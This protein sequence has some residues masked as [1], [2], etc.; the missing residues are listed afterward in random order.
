M[1]EPVPPMTNTAG[2]HEHPHDHP[3]A[4]PEIES[5]FTEIQA[6]HESAMSNLR[7]DVMAARDVEAAREAAVDAA[8]AAR[9]AEA[10]A[11]AAVMAAQAAEEITDEND[12]V[13]EE[14][15]T[16]VDEDAALEPP[17]APVAHTPP[18]AK[19]APGMWDRYPA[20]KKS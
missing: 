9:D 19:K 18:S 1:G 13:D 7:T 17:P 4:H 14:E 3:H 16:V 11:A 10:N 5:R 6:W 2:G 15:V 12:G 20:H 8:D